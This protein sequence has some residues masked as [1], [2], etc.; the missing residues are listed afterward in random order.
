MYWTEF[1]L[2]VNYNFYYYALATF[3][4]LGLMPTALLFYFNCMVHRNIKPPKR[5]IQEV[6]F[7][8]KRY[9]QERNLAIVMMAIVAVFMALH[10][11][12]N[13]VNITFIFMVKLIANCSGAHTSHNLPSY[14]D[15]P[16]WFQLIWVLSQL[17]VVINSS[18][19][20]IIYCCLNA[21]FRKQIESIT[22]PLFTRMSTF[23]SPD[24][25]E[26]V[27]SSSE[28]D[29][30]D[31]APTEASFKMVHVKIPNIV[32]IPNTP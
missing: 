11:L 14:V 31:A 27:D 3:M 12:R 25:N 15:T 24:R 9:T 26:D 19:N 29:E 18:V 28:E 22:A 4:V 16:L 5:L 6:D 2:D 10:S 20:T 8:R 32:I 21:K 23:H 17:L 7:R 30:E 13:V 1:T